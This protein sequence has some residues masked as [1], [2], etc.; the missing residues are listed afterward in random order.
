M[1]FLRLLEL[2][3]TLLFTVVAVLLS[4]VL[5]VH[6]ADVCTTHHSTHCNNKGTHHQQRYTHHTTIRLYKCVCTYV[7]SPGAP[8]LAPI[9]CVS[10]LS[11]GVSLP[12]SGE[13]PMQT[14]GLEHRPRGAHSSGGFLNSTAIP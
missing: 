2:Y 13:A 10:Y 9:S 6:A 1:Y 8:H 3:S 4:L 12:S 5:L 11:S 14:T 7:Q